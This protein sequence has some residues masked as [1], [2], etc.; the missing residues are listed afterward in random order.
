MSFQVLARVDCYKK[1][2]N[3]LDD[4]ALCSDDN[5]NDN[6]MTF[7]GHIV[8]LWSWAIMRRI[9]GAAQI[10]QVCVYTNEGKNV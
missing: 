1:T 4:L 7:A 2:L 8:Y 10:E 5:D 9:A 6:D 3:I